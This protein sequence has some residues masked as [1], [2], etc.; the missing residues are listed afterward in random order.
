MLYTVGT[1]K[2]EWLAGRA[3][4]TAGLYLTRG[5]ALEVFKAA[6]NAELMRYDIRQGRR[7]LGGDT[8]RGN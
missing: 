7:D 8:V 1:L 6:W 4:R 3:V 2:E 5:C